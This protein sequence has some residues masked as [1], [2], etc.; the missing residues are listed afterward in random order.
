MV[1]SRGR[2]F[3][4]TLG[5]PKQADTARPATPRRRLVALIA[6]ILH[7][8]LLVDIKKAE[9]SPPGYCGSPLSNAVVEN[10]SP[11]DG[12][13]YQPNLL[14]TTHGGI[15]EQ[16]AAG[17][18][19]TASRNYYTDTGNTA[20]SFGIGVW[21][22]TIAGSYAVEI[23]GA[24]TLELVN[25]DSKGLFNN[26]NNT[27]RSGVTSALDI[28]AGS[29]VIV[30][31]SGNAVNNQVW[32]LL[33][34]GANINGATDPGF[35]DSLTKLDGNLSITL[36]GLGA[37]YGVNAIRDA[38]L[39]GS[40][41]LT[42]DAQGNGI[43]TDQA[44]T[45]TTAATGKWWSQGLASDFG[46]HV[47]F[48]GDVHIKASQGVVVGQRTDSF[49]LGSLA[50]PQG[51]V[52][53]NATD[54]AGVIIFNTQST[55]LT[56]LQVSSQADGAVGVVAYSG[57]NTLE[58]LQ[59][60]TSGGKTTTTGDPGF[61]D[62][63]GLLLRQYQSLAQPTVTASGM[64]ITTTGEGSH[65]IEMEAGALTYS[66]DVTTNGPGAHA[67]NLQGGTVT[68]NAG[69]Y[70][71]TN[72]DPSAPSYALHLVQGALS[73]GTGVTFKTSGTG[74]AVIDYAPAGPGMLRV[75]LDPSTVIEADG[76]N[77]FGVLADGTNLSVGIG[78][79]IG[80][81]ALSNIKA[82]GTNSV[83]VAARN[84]TLTLNG[85]QFQN[86]AAHFG[87][88]SWAAEAARGGTVKFSAGA[89]TG[90]AGIWAA[91]GGTLDFNEDGTGA[92]Q[93][94]VRIDQ[95]NTAGGKLD[96][97]GR[98]SA[99][100]VGLLS[101]AN[102]TGA[103]NGIVN[104]GA[105][106][107]DLDGPS[108]LG[109]QTFNGTIAG[110]GGIAVTGGG[111]QVLSG[112]HVFDYEGATQINNGALQVQGGAVGRDD[113]G[114]WKAFQVNPNGVLDISGNGSSFDLG[115]VDGQGTVNLGS[116]N[117][118]VH[119]AAS[120][121]TPTF[122]GA[123]TGSGGLEV[124][125]GTLTL[126]GPNV[127]GYTGSTTVSGGTLAVSGSDISAS[128]RLFD[129][130]GAGKLD[131]S[132]A[133]ASVASVV[134]GGEGFQAGLIEGNGH[135]DLGSG[136]KYLLLDGLD[137]GNAVPG[138]TKTFSGTITG[139]GGLAKNGGGTQVF[140]NAGVFG[141]SG[142]TILNGGVLA[143]E[144][145][146]FDPA[147]FNRAFIL[148][149]GWLDLSQVPNSGG[150]KDW[151]Q[152][153]V[154]D[155][156]NG[157]AGLGG[158]I[159]ADDIIHFSIS[160]GTQTESGHLGGD[161][162]SWQ[163][164]DPVGY[165]VKDG[166]GALDL[167]GQNYYVGITR[168]DD[169][170]L[171]VHNDHNLG[172]PRY[173]RAVVLNGGNL[174]ISPNSGTFESGRTLQMQKDGTVT[175][176]GAGAT[177]SLGNVDGAGMTLTKEG[178]GA[179]T[180]SSPG[181]L[182]RAEVNAGTL[183]LAQTTVDGTATT[184]A[185][186]PAIE[187]A[188]GT[189]VRLDGGSV[190][191]DGDAIVANGTSTTELHNTSLVA[192]SGKALYRV[193]SGAGT[194]N[195]YGQTLSGVLQADGNGNALSVALLDGST[196][197]GTPVLTAGATASLSTDASSVWNV[198]GDAT[199]SSLSNQGRLQFIDDASASPSPSYHSLRVNGQYSG[200]GAVTMRTELNE[201]GN[202][203]NQHTDRLLIAGNVTGETV[204]DVQAT[205]NGANTN[206]A[207][208]H[209]PMPEE[210]ISLVQVGGSAEQNAFKLSR[211][212][213]TSEGSAFQYR[214]FAY[215]PDSA[216]GMPS[217]N[218]LGDGQTVQ[219]DYRLQTACTDSTGRVYA[220]ACDPNVDNGGGGGGD[221]GR[222]VLVPQG[223]T[224]LVAPLALLNYESV[225][226]DSLVRRLGDV[227]LN[228]FQQPGE[229]AEMFVRPLASRSSYSSN[230]SFRDYGYGF[231]QDIYAVQIGGNLLR[232]MRGNQE[233]RL[234]A[235]VTL[236]ST[237]INPDA[238]SVESSRATVDARGLA[239][240]G[241]WRND[242][243]WY[244][245][246]VLSAAHY[247]GDVTT[248]QSQNAG[249]VVANGFDFSLEGGRTFVLKNG[250]EIE[251]MVQVLGQVLRFKAHEDV[252]GI[253][254]QPGDVRALTGR[255]G[256]RF[257][258]PIPSTDSW[259][260]YVRLQYQQTWMSAQDTNLSGTVFDVGAPG[261]ALRLGMGASG[262]LTPKLSLYGEISGQRRLGNGFNNISAT[263]GLRYD[264]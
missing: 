169:G 94:I 120:D 215:G 146:G 177:A 30:K 178:I 23:A 250:L 153:T 195:A 163:P 22:G 76:V 187:Q 258:M 211:D 90:G 191:S 165:L 88:Q 201:G 123:I 261:K 11:T 203:S 49:I 130:E 200:G 29:S 156:T 252:D 222:P 27:Y 251:P 100:N 175:V 28:R 137:A 248:T 3:Q 109:I 168:I 53:T 12:T 226:I 172:D 86:D 225:V 194:L 20:L 257:A 240:T 6:M 160:S 186:A 238:N 117:L 93:S 121:P 192:G 111:V 132:A 116:A 199:L 45:G 128:H 68:L 184:N 147:T 33:T 125:G 145:N 81:L 39:Q 157:R 78:G 176:E 64:S 106:T 73:T 97:S 57:T 43:P 246:G 54:G 124:Q 134:P 235:A 234:G 262:M 229:T 196:Y 230:L 180:L 62:S 219:W 83:A 182:G 209:K 14:Q 98:T 16:S 136:G 239:L 82:L 210:G 233:M 254:A 220:G 35:G 74:T 167:D 249:R 115:T 47:D 92:S 218:L 91:E 241:T 173:E 164:A 158:V 55:T 170:D 69:T 133:A 127:F 207:G 253:V 104:L 95:G 7:C 255:L 263:A 66:G 42:V 41:T 162:S 84:A 129:V 193:T 181:V 190:I 122:S 237:T 17:T 242:R 89:Q 5:L 56:N 15:V 259:I 19:T 118:V 34:Q 154:S 236:G 59:I 79:D 4:K 150:L 185:S 77:A 107:L 99:L 152:L 50:A 217:Q 65:G 85:G 13:C 24:Q 151:Q 260:P 224:Y 114:N 26:G 171:I 189:T 71:T 103:T 143:L 214:L 110:S 144:G 138:T 140:S 21:S 135:V 174:I 126:A 60:G 108:A 205:G 148:D 231:G 18:L 204:L 206:V 8:G 101:S 149:G 2:F 80:G 159:T 96:L 52:T 87:P 31:M 102:T 227:R 142:A 247:S 139:N 67:V 40:G 244:V 32:G 44:R 202:P 61:Y 245:D 212:Y 46:S 37:S 75:T 197:T 38:W 112:A 63:Y 141:Y 216:N 72:T 161:G 105:N 10:A 264:F 58:N 213:V 223:S 183:E 256:V 36:T 198:N 131:I 232:L 1:G 9:A 113:T 119:G 221:G 208:N 25:N 179:L 70:E 228:R 155:S 188:A 51:I 243:G 166:A 48:T